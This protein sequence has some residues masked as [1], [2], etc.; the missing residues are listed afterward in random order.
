MQLFYGKPSDDNIEAYI[1][2]LVILLVNKCL[3]MVEYGFK[4]GGSWVVVAR[5]TVQSDGTSVTDD[6]SGRVPAGANTS[7]ALWH[8]FLVRWTPS[9][10]QPEG[11]IKRVSHP[12]ARFHHA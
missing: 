8:S 1:E 11:Q 7:S 3:K 4:R 10:R 9:L 6:R 2:E 5:Y 12:Y